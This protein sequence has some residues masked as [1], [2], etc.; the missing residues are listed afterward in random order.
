MRIQYLGS[1]NH[2]AVR[3]VSP[4]G[5]EM[6][7][8]DADMLDHH[9]R[10]GHLSTAALIDRSPGAEQRLARLLVLLAC[11]QACAEG[12]RCVVRDCPRRCIAAAK[13]EAG[14]A[15]RLTG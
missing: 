9:I 3:V 8:L 13:T 11:A 6:A 2:T 15:T 1:G 14:A 4:E 12:M 10:A 5:R 7:A